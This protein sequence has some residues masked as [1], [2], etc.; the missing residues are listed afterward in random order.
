MAILVYFMAGA[1]NVH[2]LD[3]TN[4]QS[5]LVIIFSLADIDKVRASILKRL[6]SSILRRQHV[7]ITL[8]QVIDG[9]PIH[10]AYESST[11]MRIELLSRTTISENAISLATQF[12]ESSEP[13]DSISLNPT[14]CFASFW[15]SFVAEQYRR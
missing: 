14:V 9:L 3:F 12:C 4:T 5:C 6:L 2:P 15:S 8:A 7:R 1:I 13:I 10:T 11:T